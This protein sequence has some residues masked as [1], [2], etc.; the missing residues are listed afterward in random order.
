[1]KD[2][3]FMER[4]AR[5]FENILYELDEKLDYKVR[6]FNLIKWKLEKAS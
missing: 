3:A 1:M 2:Q 4:K 6:H 5:T